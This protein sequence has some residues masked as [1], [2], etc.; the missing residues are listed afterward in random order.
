MK[1]LNNTGLVLLFFILYTTVHAQQN[2]TLNEPDLNRPTLFDSF[3]NRIPVD[4]SE[5][6]SFFSNEAA[7][8]ADVQ[9]K[10][11]DK[12]IPGF[13]GK[14]VSKSSKYNNTLRSVVIRSTRFNG[15][16]LTLSSSTTT[17]GAAIYTG[18]IIS[19]QHGDL[20]VLKKEGDQYFLIK[21]KYHELINE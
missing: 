1:Y 7:K 10:F 9:L 16:T 5:L 11:I 18:R 21:K 3:P 13:A 17:D 4:I 8:G 15:A 14:I 6:K 12:K 20:F 19:F 2:A